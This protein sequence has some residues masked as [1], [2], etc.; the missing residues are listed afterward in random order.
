MNRMQRGMTL[1]EIVIAATIFALVVALSFS[2]SLFSARSFNESIS[3]SY[4][5]TKGERALKSMTEEVC[6][7]YALDPT[8][9]VEDGDTF[10]G[11]QINYRVPINFGQPNL[12]K[13]GATYHLVSPA[14]LPVFR[15]T[16]ANPTMP[17]DFYLTLDFGWRDDRFLVQNADTGSDAPL[18]GPGLRTTGAP[19][20]VSIVSGLTPNGHMSFRFVKNRNAELGVNGIF[21]ESVHQVD[22]DN[23]G[24]LTSRYVVGYLERCIW[25]NNDRNS[26]TGQLG[27]ETLMASSRMA[28]ADSNVLLPING[29][30]TGDP[31]L[32]KTAR[33]FVKSGSRV[34]ISIWLVSVGDSQLPRVVKCSTSVF[35]RNN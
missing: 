7:A 13:P 35:L 33:L 32:M 22:I 8:T 31:E 4:L 17:G 20:D 24:A 10:Y 18:Q 29:T 15:E 25:L 30:A 19:S 21:D 2:V 3:F 34:D 6:D 1:M 12:V 23:D 5:Q 11:A 14:G 27:D 9:V 28:L 16:V 26:A